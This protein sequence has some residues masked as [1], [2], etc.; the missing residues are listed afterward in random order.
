MLDSV[1]Y[2]ITTGTLAPSSIHLPFKK[3]EV[4]DARFDTSKL[5]FE[6]KKWYTYIS[7]EDFRKIKLKNG[8]ERAITEYYN[9]YYR[10][11][12]KDNS[13]ELL[14]VLRTLWIDNLP[15]SEFKQQQNADI[16][17]EA[18]QNIYVKAEY[19]L[20]RGADYYPLKRVDT[21]YQLTEQNINSGEFNFRKND[22]S[23]FLFTLKS[24]VEVYDFTGLIGQGN[25]RRK[26][27]LHDIDSFNRI[28]FRVPALIAESRKAGIYLNGKDFANNNPLHD[29][30]Y[31]IDKKGRLFS[32]QYSK[33]EIPYLIYI[34]EEGSY[35][36]NS[37][38][39]QVLQ[40]GNTFEL[41][42]TSNVYLSKTVAG[43]IIDLIP[44]TKFR[45]MPPL[46]R[47]EFHLGN[48]ARLHVIQAPRQINP[49]TGDLY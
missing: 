3:I 6:L 27:T 33:L 44:D 31:S 39:T 36:R 24:L 5:G 49:E 12:L 47:V 29:S 45:G 16:V 46:E 26:L 23:F 37:R 21:L 4:I 40:V 9:D 42:V 43:N 2:T 38:S 25:F 10:L 32:K 20:K 18:Y 35:S 41:F 28:R 30:D 48:G 7:P 17:W 34:T 15:T 8:I 11:C 1:E 19:Y 22:L 13:N 14:M